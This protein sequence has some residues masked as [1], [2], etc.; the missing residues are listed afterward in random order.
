MI[1]KIILVIVIISAMLLCASCSF[2]GSTDAPEADELHS[3]ITL[4][5]TNT[6]VVTELPEGCSYTFS[7]DSH[8]VCNAK[9]EQLAF[10]TTDMA[11]AWDGIRDEM[12]HE[13]TVRK[14]ISEG[15]LSSGNEYFTVDYNDG[16]IFNALI[17]V[18]PSTCLWIDCHDEALLSELLGLIT[19]T[20]YGYYTK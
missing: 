18:N 5:N 9:G 8:W 17:R 20:A 16:E 13:D 4:G 11:S 1:K 14:L 19:V 15:E 12:T 7:E 2:I 10:L 3:I 6:T